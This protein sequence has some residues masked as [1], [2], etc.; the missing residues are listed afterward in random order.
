MSGASKSTAGGTG[1][2]VVGD[3]R[4]RPNVEDAANFNIRERMKATVGVVFT[5]NNHRDMGPSYM[6]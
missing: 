2:E 4:K 3:P 5:E 6:E 1:S